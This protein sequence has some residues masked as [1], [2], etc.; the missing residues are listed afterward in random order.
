MRAVYKYSLCNLGSPGEYHVTVPKG[1]KLLRV[2]KQHGGLYLWA[3]VE[4]NITERE[5]IKF[6]VAGTGQE[7]HGWWNLT[8]IDT[9]F[10]GEYV[11]HVFDLGRV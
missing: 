9:I 2:G 11:W 10:D 7:L 8:Y 3:I 6:L 5:T 4:T 1:A